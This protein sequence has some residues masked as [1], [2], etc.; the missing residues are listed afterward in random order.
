MNEEI[1]TFCPDVGGACMG[2]KCSAYSKGLQIDII[3]NTNTINQMISITDTE[4]NDLINLR[5]GMDC[6]IC[7]KYDKFVTQESH[8][9][10]ND[11]IDNFKK[12]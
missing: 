2:N 12:R 8:D 6:N 9:M 1:I 5:L 4:E 11:V 10:F 3:T 7:K